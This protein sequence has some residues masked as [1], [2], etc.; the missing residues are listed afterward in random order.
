[1]RLPRYACAVEGDTG[2]QCLAEEES[3]DLGPHRYR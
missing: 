1:M 2:G 3:Q